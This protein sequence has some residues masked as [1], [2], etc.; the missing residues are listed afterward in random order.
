MILPDVSRWLFR[1]LISRFGSPIKK[2]QWDVY[3][4]PHYA[5]GINHAAREAK[6]LGLKGISVIEFGVAGGNGLVAMELIAGELS[7]YHGIDIDVYGFDTGSGQ[8][9]PLDYRDCPYIWATNQ[10]KMDE[11]YLRSRLKKAKLFI[12]LAKD[13]LNNFLASDPLPIGFIS[14]DM[15]YYSSTVDV[16]PLFDNP[17][18]YFIPRVFCYFDDTIGFENELH[19]EFTGELLAINEF[20]SSH[21]TLKMARINGL[22][23]K[24]RFP[25]FWNDAIFVLHRFSDCRYSTFINPWGKFEL[26][27]S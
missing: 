4:Y 9:P 24:R 7:I 20:N 2:V 5:Y 8:P 12:G 23:H 25:A 16:M 3:P 11:P 18:N 27:L 21:K 1:R 17:D 15:D 14:F 13:N 22:S 6:A 19:C 26:P 10:F